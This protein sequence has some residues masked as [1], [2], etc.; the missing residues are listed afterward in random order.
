MPYVYENCE[1][2]DFVEKLAV[3]I[4]AAAMP[5]IIAFA[6]AGKPDEA[7]RLAGFMVRRGADMGPIREQVREA[8]APQYVETI[9]AA[10]PW[11]AD[12]TFD[13]RPPAPDP[14]SRD[15][16]AELDAAG[17]KGIPAAGLDLAALGDSVATFDLPTG[18][19]PR[20]MVRL[21]AHDV[22]FNPFA[23]PYP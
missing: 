9:M 19:R 22:R 2:L 1:I 21:K 11:L 18:G 13:P 23:M 15:L 6:I 16:A 14:A 17:P 8:C 3:P 7:R 20:K 10:L 12:A 4:V 5:K